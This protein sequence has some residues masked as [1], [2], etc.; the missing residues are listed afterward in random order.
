M[1]P[2]IVFYLPATMPE[3]TTVWEQ[4][5]WLLMREVDALHN[6][7][8]LR[9]TTLGFPDGS[10]MVQVLLDLAVPAAKVIKELA[11]IVKADMDREKAALAVGEKFIPIEL[12]WTWPARTAVR[13]DNERKRA[14]L[15]QEGLE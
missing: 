4:N 7:G 6:Q 14:E 8:G 2:H 13:L 11:G 5:G 10:R 9:V 12:D 15:D 3:P 1:I